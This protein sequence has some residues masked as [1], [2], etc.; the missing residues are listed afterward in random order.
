LFS[1]SSAFSV[2]NTLTKRRTGAALGATTGLPDLPAEAGLATLIYGRKYGKAE[3]RY[4]AICDGR[5]DFL[6]RGSFCLKNAREKIV[7]AQFFCMGPPDTDR[8][9]W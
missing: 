4:F 9:L 1:C 2:A 5:F 7:A 3:Q 6:V 8:H